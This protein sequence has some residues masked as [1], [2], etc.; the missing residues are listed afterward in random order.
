MGAFPCSG[1]SNGIVR[2]EFHTKMNP[3]RR[4]VLFKYDGNPK[5]Y[6]DGLGKIQVLSSISLKLKSNHKMKVD[7]KVPFK[8]LKSEKEIVVPISLVLESG[9]KGKTNSFNKKN[10]QN[11][12]DGDE[13]QFIA[14]MCFNEIL[15]NENYYK[16]LKKISKTKKD[17]NI[18]KRAIVEEKLQFINY[19]DIRDIKYEVEVLQDY[20]KNIQL[21]CYLDFISF[22][23]VALDQ[24]ISNVV[25]RVT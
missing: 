13:K 9:K 20:D 25:M 6:P 3:K 22:E 4:I 14:W 21:E 8:N 11:H 15:T 5:K 17:I 19:T 2:G 16:K 24:E 18:I 23:P 7:I 12:F 10:I 1:R